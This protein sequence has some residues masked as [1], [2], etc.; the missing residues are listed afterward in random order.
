MQKLSSGYFMI[1]F[2]PLAGLWTACWLTAE[3]QWT[4]RRRVAALAGAGLAAFVMTLPFALPYLTVL[5]LF[6]SSG[7][8]LQEAAVFSADVAAWATASADLTVWG[9]LALLRKGEGELFLGVA[10]PVLA[11]LGVASASVSRAH[12]TTKVFAVVIVLLA[13]WMALGPFPSLMGRRLPI[14]SL[15]AL[16]H[17]YVPGF[18]VA[19]VPTRF[20]MILLVGGALLSGFGALAIARRPTLL[21]IVAG[22]AILDGAA[23]PMPRNVLLPPHLVGGRPLTNRLTPTRP[24]PVYGYLATLPPSAA[25]A[26]FPLGLLDHDVRYMFYSATLPSAIVNGYSG[27]VPPDWG[28]RVRL[29]SYPMRAI[30]SAWSHLTSLK[31]THAVVHGDAWDDATGADL[32]AAFERRGARPVYRDGSTVVYELPRP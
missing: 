12:T 5:D 25:I 22:V 20:Q 18:N 8:P 13:A 7:R 24:P 14:P 1:Y 15:F 28:E 9:W 10:L 23:V 32:G 4:N 11:T 21:G 6:G 26:H 2:A 3:R 30:D 29:L 17:S 19:R 27:A 31:T 16:A